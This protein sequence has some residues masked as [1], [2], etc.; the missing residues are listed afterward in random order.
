MRWS[1]PACASAGRAA[2]GDAASH[3][4][5][6]RLSPA[7]AAAWAAVACSPA[8]SAIRLHLPAPRPTGA[9][10]LRAAILGRDPRKL[11]GPGIQLLRAERLGEEFARAELHRLPMLLFLTR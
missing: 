1:V 11:R 2:E 4:A 7:G 3:R 5:L 10:G 9:S 8:R 6:A